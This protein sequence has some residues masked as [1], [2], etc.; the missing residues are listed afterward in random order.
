MA[1]A[2]I[3]TRDFCPYCHKALATLDRLGVAYTKIDVGAGQEVLD[4]MV[5]RTGQHTV[6]QI[7]LHVGGSDDFHELLEAGALSGLLTK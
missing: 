7:F 1:H 5:A 2:I 6:P 3:Y 4:E